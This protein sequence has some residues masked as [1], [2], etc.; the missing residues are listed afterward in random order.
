MTKKKFAP[1]FQ[2]DSVA[3]I[4]ASSIRGKPGHEVIQNI[5]ANGY[6]GKLYLV[7]PK[8]GELLGMPV[9]SSIDDLPEGTDLAIIILPDPSCKR[10]TTSSS[11]MCR[12]RD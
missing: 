1:F 8:G 10:D 5:L 12:K 6:R 11:G 9:Y 2:P 3:I 7:N 4:G